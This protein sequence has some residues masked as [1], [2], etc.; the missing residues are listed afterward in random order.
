M[1]QID[2]PL[3]QLRAGSS[4]V[5]SEAITADGLPDEFAGDPSAPD[6]PPVERGF[7]GEEFLPAEDDRLENPAQMDWQSDATRRRRQ[8]ALVATVSIFTLIV[9]ALGFGWFVRSYRQ[10]DTVAADPSD[11]VASAPEPA[12]DVTTDPPSDQEPVASD[13]P[14]SSDA[15]PEDAAADTT[16]ESVTPK[17]AEDDGHVVAPEPAVAEPAAPIIPV[18]LMP[19]SPLAM[20]TDSAPATRDGGASSAIDPDASKLAKLPPGLAKYTPFLLQDANAEVPTLQA[21]PTMDEVAI[22]GAAEEDI[23]PLDQT[24]ARAVNVKS[25]MAI[26]MAFRNKDYPLTD[27]VLMISQITGV[28]IQVDWVSF[29]IAGADVDRRVELPKSMTAAVDVLTQ[30]AISI[31]A[32]VRTEETLLTLTIADD[33]FAAAVAQIKGLDDFGDHVESARSVLDDFLRP[34]E[35]PVA[36][37]RQFDELGELAEVKPPPIRDP[38]QDEQLAAIASEILR[39][40]RGIPPKVAD[41]RLRRWAHWSVEQ[42][43]DWSVVSQGNPGAQIDVPIAMAGF[44]KRVARTNDTACLVNWYDANRRGATPERLLLPDARH[45]LASMLEQTFSPLGLRVRQ[46]DASHWWVGSDVTYDRLSVIA[47]SPPLGD[48]VGVFVE[49]VNRIM[50]GATRDH[51]RVAIDVQ[52]NRALMMLPRY[53]VRQLPKLIE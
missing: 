45:G 36:P 39:R 21:P 42:D 14:E 34:A 37:Q 26:K 13:L 32:E 22:D 12:T 11:P 44:L 10:P 38:R 24:E 16:M 48:N 28:P 31:G 2:G 1:V 20:N 40:M 47:A 27:L 3:E 41:D 29:D 4:S 25:D 18:D 53:V 23:D 52:S 46:V 51:Y 33:P 19:K 35:P 43:A 30:V 15:V 49:K 5:D 50:A 6:R 17:P 9:A 7:A 8:I